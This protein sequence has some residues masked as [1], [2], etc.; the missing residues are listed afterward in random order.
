MASHKATHTSQNEGSSSGG[1]GAFFIYPDS[2]MLGMSFASR[3]LGIR[4]REDRGFGG[5][6]PRINY[7]YKASFLPTKFTNC[8]PLSFNY[9]SNQRSL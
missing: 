3:F 8:G 9:I 2:I 4:K 1:F 5:G 7:K 6:P